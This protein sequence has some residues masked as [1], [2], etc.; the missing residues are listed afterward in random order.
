MRGLISTR[1]AV[2]RH[3]KYLFSR[4]NSDGGNVVKLYCLWFVVLFL[5]SLNITATSQEVITRLQNPVTARLGVNYEYWKANDN[6][7]NQFSLPLTMIYPF[8]DRLR[9]SIVTAPA[10]ATLKTNKNNVLNGFS[11]IRFQGHYLFSN[12]KWL[13][14]FGLNLPT[15]KSSLTTEEFNVSN[16]LAIHAFQFQVPS[17][18]QGLDVNAGIVT[19]SEVGDF[20][21]GTGVS[22]MYKGTFKPFKDFDYEYSP[23]YEINISTGLD[24]KFDNDFRLMGDVIYTIYGSD[25]GNDEE[26]FR[27]G[28]KLLI[29]LLSAFK[30]KSSDMM[31]MLRNR[32][33]GKNKTGIGDVFEEE[34]KNSNNNEFEIFTQLAFPYSPNLRLLILL[35]LK[36]Y[37]NNDYDTGGANLFGAGGGARLTLLKSL[38]FDTNF[39]FYAGNIKNSKEATDITGIKIMGGFKYFFGI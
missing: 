28:N 34:R 29:Q 8:N 4:R 6:V 11:D 18:G 17:M 10:F 22:F 25:K 39:R 12:E 3:K 23:G 32:F 2:I 33:K 35:D 21:L 13:L 19:A 30:F 5:F 20:V 26:I 16:T 31:I 36:F 27:S 7:I 14:T 15:G 38:V 1:S 24:R 37:S 9:L